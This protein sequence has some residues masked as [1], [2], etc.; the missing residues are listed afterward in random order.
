MLFAFGGGFRSSSSDL[1]GFST[2]NSYTTIFLDSGAFIGAAIIFVFC[3]SPIKAL[4]ITSPENRHSS[5]LI[6]LA[7]F[8]TFL[9]VE[10]VFN[11]YL[12]AIGNPTSLMSLLILFALSIRKNL[13]DS[14]DHLH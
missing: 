9:I 8:M 6:L 1:I 10:S 11:R 4:R 3:Y 5:P 13:T 2:E 12:L 14:V 7:S